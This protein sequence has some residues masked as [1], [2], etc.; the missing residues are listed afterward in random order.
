MYARNRRDDSKVDVLFLTVAQTFALA[1]DYFVISEHKSILGGLFDRTEIKFKH[2]PAAISDADLTFV[3]EYFMLLAY[4]QIAL[5]MGMQA[6]PDPSFPTVMQGPENLFRAGGKAK[7]TC[8]GPH[9]S[10]CPAPGDDVHNC[11]DSA[12]TSDC[13]KQKACCCG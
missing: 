2:K 1:D 9:E 5:A 13:D 10:C 3:S 8:T 12:R 11:P 7:D 6:P 4:Q